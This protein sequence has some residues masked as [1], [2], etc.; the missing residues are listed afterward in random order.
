MKREMLSFS[1]QSLTSLTKT[2]IMLAEDRAVQDAYIFL[3]QARV[4]GFS[5]ILSYYSLKIVNSFLEIIF[6]LFLFYKNQYVSHREWLILSFWAYPL[7]TYFP[8]WRRQLCF[9]KFDIL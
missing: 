8:K 4:K 5:T 9:S 7:P 1:L 3:A 2:V 6:S